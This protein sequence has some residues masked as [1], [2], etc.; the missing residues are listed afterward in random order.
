MLFTH[1]CVLQ[2][3]NCKNF[4]PIET[5][6]KVRLECFSVFAKNLLLRTFIDGSNYYWLH[7]LNHQL[8]RQFSQPCFSIVCVTTTL[9]QVQPTRTHYHRQGSSCSTAQFSIYFSFSLILSALA[10]TEPSTNSLQLL[11]KIRFK[12][13]DPCVVRRS[14]VSLQGIFQ[15]TSTLISSFSLSAQKW[16]LGWWNIS[17]RSICNLLRQLTDPDVCGCVSKW[18]QMLRAQLKWNKVEKEQKSQISWRRR[19]S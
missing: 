18:T 15:L 12:K 14:R 10:E 11:E 5:M 19:W 6:Q 9:T 16:N 3:F 4:L 17:S 7:L 13:I 2:F 1:P 8:I